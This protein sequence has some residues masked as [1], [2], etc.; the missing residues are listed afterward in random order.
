MILWKKLRGPIQTLERRSLWIHGRE[1]LAIVP[2]HH[3]VIAKEKTKLILLG[4][5]F[6]IDGLSLYI[7]ITLP[8]MFLHG[9]S[10]LSRFEYTFVTIISSYGSTG[11]SR[12]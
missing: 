11:Q 5:S 8:V 1:T 12:L 2:N 6:K 3:R 10:K 4:R 9:F 7:L